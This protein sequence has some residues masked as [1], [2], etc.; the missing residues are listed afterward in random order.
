M[1]D[2][3]RALQP[4]GKIQP[5]TI[6]RDLPKEIHEFTNLSLDDDVL[7]DNVLPPH[8]PGIDTKITLQ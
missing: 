8:R 7:K 4:K 3:K 2:I 6:Q 1:Y 5:E